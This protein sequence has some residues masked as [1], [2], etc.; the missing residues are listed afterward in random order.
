MLSAVKRIKGLGPRAPRGS[1]R[2]GNCV[3]HYWAEALEEERVEVGLTGSLG[4][5]PA[6]LTDVWSD[7]GAR[8]REGSARGVTGSVSG[9]RILAGN[10]GSVSWAGSSAV[11]IS[12]SGEGAGWG[13]GGAVVGTGRAVQSRYRAEWGSPQLGHFAG[14][15]SQQASTG[16]WLPSFGQT[17]LGHL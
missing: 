2:A 4:G 12:S 5:G 16:R 3:R 9:K 7:G 15:T 14:E 6:N 11:S 10:G 8:R 1:S 17:G 13:G